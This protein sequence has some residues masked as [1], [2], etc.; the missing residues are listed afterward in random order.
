MCISEVYSVYLDDHVAFTHDVFYDF[1]GL[2][3]VKHD[4][5]PMSW[6]QGSFDLNSYVAEVLHF[7]PIGHS[8]PATYR[9]AGKQTVQM[10]TRE[11]YAGIVHDVKKLC[12]R[13]FR[14]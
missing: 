6:V 14:L 12:R 13:T 2:V 8:I 9:E 7:M 3:D 10:V 5:I 1:K 4:A 11:V